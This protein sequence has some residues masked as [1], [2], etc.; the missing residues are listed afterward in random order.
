MTLSYAELIAADYL[1]ARG[2]SGYYISDI[3]PHASDLPALAARSES[4][5]FARLSGQRYS[6]LAAVQRPAD[7][8][9]YPYPFI[10]GQ[11]DASLFE[12]P[13]RRLCALR[14]WRADRAGAC[15]FSPSRRAAK[16]LPAGLF[17]DQSGQNSGRHCADCPGNAIWRQ[18]AALTG[19]TSRAATSL[20]EPDPVLR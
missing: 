11:S 12:H 16:P 20:K 8:E 13:N 18:D 15:V 14:R 19:P 3:A 9:T 5:D 6:G 7:W 2:R 17:V 1:V 4:P 10:Y